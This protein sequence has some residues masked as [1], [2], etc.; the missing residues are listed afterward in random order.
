MEGADFLKEATL[1][2]REIINLL[3][4][5]IMIIDSKVYVKYTNKAF[6][7]NFGK[8]FIRTLERGPGDLLSCV[9][10]FQTQEGCGHSNECLSCQLRKYIGEAVSGEK[11]TNQ[12]EIPMTLQGEWGE[13]K[14]WFEVQVIPYSE[15]EE[16]EFLVTFIDVSM[17][18]KNSL[19]LLE[20]KRIAEETN[21]TK[22]E[23]IANMSH[24][25]RTPLNGVIGMI[26]MT[27]MTKLD[28]EQ[29]ENLEVAK[30]CADNLLLLINDILDLSK[31]ESDKMVLEEHPFELRDVIQRAADTQLAKVAEKELELVCDVER[32][33]PEFFN[34]DGHKLQ[35]IL[36]NLLANAVKFT[37]HGKVTLEVRNLCKL[38]DIYTLSFSVEDTGI[39]I[40]KDKQVSLFKPFSQA[41]GSITRKYGG[42][43][44][45]LAISQKLVGIM[46]GE[47]KVKSQENRGSVFYFTIQLR[48]SEGLKPENEETVVWKNKD[49]DYEVLVV[50]DDKF[51][52]VVMEQILKKLG[53]KKI[54]IV[55]NGFEAIR[56]WEK[57]KPNLII[58]DIVLPGMEGTEVT[59]IIRDREKLT[60][61][62]V[63]II[64]LTACAMDGDRENILGQGMDAYLAKPVDYKELTAI[65]KEAT[66]ANNQ[67]EE[68]EDMLKAAYADW[69]PGGVE[70][71]HIKKI[72]YSDKKEIQTVVSDIYVILEKKS[73]VP[74]IFEAVEKNAH[75]IKIRAQKKGYDEIRSRAFRMEMASRKKDDVGIR[76]CCSQIEK[77]LIK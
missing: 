1:G 13:E 74:N 24:E 48:R 39:G 29:K 30:Q 3:P 67:P 18:K 64:A 76:K 20:N 27:L 36:N 49:E 61:G 26:E 19:K 8:G 35:Q 43:G 17:Y 70:Q 22:S 21:K 73:E 56:Q 38:E 65:L 6:E 45:G 51:S 10:S 7:H 40:A 47:I 9:N 44:L 46:G 68:P 55:E 12:I 15:S 31:A 5:N 32:K 60:G 66:Q 16:G 37:E 71:E 75:L 58:M 23:F 25:I 34:G 57:E 52:Q 62:H 69:I 72:S 4:I 54:T 77:L 11:V 53:Y 2:T 42:T 41:D 59:R 28:E 33:I 14:R 50:E 63:P